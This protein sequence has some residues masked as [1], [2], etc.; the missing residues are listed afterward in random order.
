MRLVLPWGHGLQDQEVMPPSLSSDLG[1]HAGGEVLQ[2]DVAWRR[3]VTTT[4]TSQRES[5]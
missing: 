2:A 3:A 5:S 4:L 1:G